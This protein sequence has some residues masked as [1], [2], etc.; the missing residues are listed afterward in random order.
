[1][2][3]HEARSTRPWT[4]AVVG[5][6]PRGLAVLERLMAHERTH[7]HHPEVLVH[8][9][10]PAAAGSGAVWRT[11]QSPLLLTNTV[12]SQITIFTDDSSQLQGPIEPGPSLYEWS[13]GL[14]EDPTENEARRLGPDSYPSRALYGRYLQMALCRTLDRAPE[15]VRVHVHHS[16]AVAL[17]DTDGV[18]GG[19]QGLRLDDGTRLHGLDA[20]VLALGHRP[21]RPTPREAQAASLAR[22]H[23]LFYVPPSNP[24]DVDLTSVPAGE[25]V[26]LRGLG[27][28]F[29]DYTTLLTVGRGGRFVATD[30]GLRY[31]PSGREPQLFASSRRGVPYHSRGENEKGT[32]GRHDPLVVTEEALTALPRPIDFTRDLWPMIDREVQVVYYGTLLADLGHD[33]DE[34]VAGLLDLPLGADPAPLLDRWDV[35]GEER[36]SWPRLARPFA[37]REF[38][39]RDDFGRW[40]VAYL[41]TDV[42]EARRGNVSGPLKAALD[43]LRDLRNELRL[44][45]DH[46]GLGLTQRDLDGWYTPLNGYLSIGPPASRIEEMVALIESGVLSL[47]GPGSWIRFDA[48]RRAFVTG[49]SD[50]P[51]PLVAARALIECRLPD[52]DVRRTADPL[53]RHLLETE[54]AAPY[55]VRAEG[56]Q[57]ETG[58]LAVGPRPYHLLSALGQPHPRR[59]A[60]GIPTES[61]HWVTAAGVRPGVDSVTMKDADAIALAVLGLAPP[62]HV[63]PDVGPADGVDHLSVATLAGSPA[64]DPNLIGVI[65]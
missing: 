3:S 42:A 6:G 45:V 43:V 28:N 5:A 51:G 18:V 62:R 14:G 57:Y 47:T 50:V 30:A 25:P 31:E 61:V 13:R 12:A 54:Q 4:V 53:L 29:F 59:F 2:T 1:M 7:R 58:G 34:V 56:G 35:P 10:D 60:Y 37:D 22:I 15:H 24:A 55:V 19:P 20:V 17:A 46:G 26:L 63:P 44:A 64:V 38:A 49:S 36:W 27:L 40:L 33:R 23:D 39:D 41:R 8:L 9:V 65:V 11:D 52:P 32:A 21:A 16:W 48:T